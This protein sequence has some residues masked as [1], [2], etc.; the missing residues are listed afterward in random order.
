ML[1]DMQTIKKQLKTQISYWDPIPEYISAR[2]QRA[3]STET[4]T[5]RSSSFCQIEPI[6]AKVSTILPRGRSTSSTHEKQK[7]KNASKTQ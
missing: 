1:Y 7:Y 4:I 3:Q 6:R 5:D 2:Q